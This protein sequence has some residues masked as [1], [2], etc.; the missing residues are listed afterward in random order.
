MINEERGYREKPVFV[1]EMR[2]PLWSVIFS[3]YESEITR[4]VRVAEKKRS[5]G[6]GGST[7]VSSRN[8]RAQILAVATD[9]FGH[10]GY[11]DTKWADIAAEVGVGSTALYHYFESKLHCLY[12]ITAEAIEVFRTE[13]DQVTAEA[14]FT[15]GIVNVLRA[16]FELTDH[17]VQR[18]RVLV[19]E[20][21]RVGSPRKSPRE[22]QARQ[23][24]RARTHDLEIAW[25]THLAR[26]ME[27]GIIADADPQLLT[28]AV[29]GLYNSVWHWYRPEG[30]LTLQE[31]SDFYVPRH[32][33]MMGLPIEAGA[34]RQPRVP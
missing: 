3:S 13:F 6:S 8:K 4:G 14:D 32:L 33:A 17:E 16:G 30:I 20:Q 10:Q 1:R 7:R 2:S 27:Q 5:V 26:G 11:E 34:P 25:A 19:A 31:V 29:L 18:N 28:H 12:V 21:G 24:A 15:E 9:Y 22:E 23:I